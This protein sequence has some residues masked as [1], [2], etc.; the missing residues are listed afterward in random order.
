MRTWRASPRSPGTTSWRGVDGAGNAYV[1]SIGFDF[2]GG[3][4][5]RGSWRSSG[6]T[7]LPDASPT[8]WPSP[9]GWP[10][11]TMAGLCWSPRPT[12]T[13]I[14]AF[15]IVADGD[16]ERTAGVGEDTG[17]TTPTASA[18]TRR[19]RSGMP[20]WAVGAACGSERAGRSFPQFDLDRREFACA[21]SRGDDPRLFVVGQHYGG[22][23]A[24]QPSGRVVAFPAPAPGAGKP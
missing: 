13:C 20:T 4:P 8:T 1:N 12:P 19:E 11:P 15:D 3:Q 10:S 9:T 21:L 2:P 16:L 6:R 23:G 18:S 14:T 7:G 24:A 17:A 5:P 22:P